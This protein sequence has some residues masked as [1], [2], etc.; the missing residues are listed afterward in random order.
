MQPRRRI[1]DHLELDRTTRKTVCIRLPRL[2]MQRNLPENRVLTSQTQPQF[3]ARALYR[4]SH[5]PAFNINF[6]EAYFQDTEEQYITKVADDIEN[7]IPLIEAGFELA[8]EYGEAKIFKKKIT[9]WYR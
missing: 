1:R 6:E 8:A 3:C 7:A 2:S 5:Q 4:S 9:Q